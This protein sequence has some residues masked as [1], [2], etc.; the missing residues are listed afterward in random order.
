MRAMRIKLG[1]RSSPLAL[2]QTEL[3]RRAILA[4]RPELANC[5]DIVNINT[6][7]DQIRNCAIEVIGGRGVF[8]DE[9]DDAVAS[10]EVDL[11]VHSA[12]DLPV[13]I[14]PGLLLAATLGRED[15]REAFVSTQY[16]SLAAVPKNAVLGSASLRRET[17]VK[18]LRPDLSFSLLRGNV[19]ERVLA[20]DER[21]LNGTILAVAG[22]KR[23]GLERY[24]RE[25]FTP[26]TLMPDPG[27]GAIGI[28]CRSD[29]AVARAIASRVNHVLT[30]KAVIAE[31]AFLE[32]AAGR[33]VVGALACI[34]NQVFTLSA[35]AATLD[36][37]IVWHQSRQGCSSAP[38]ALAQRLA[39]CLPHSVAQGRT[40]S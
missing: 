38:L 5:I 9:L 20:L 12:K 32:A 6:R 30:Y 25:V 29:N 36:G 23:L 17:L 1:T 22:L 40:A 37:T 26:Q 24:I 28:V 19:D 21:R 15:P 35:V 10:G 39:A 27:Q 34:S 13:P 14:S 3:V 31:R 7:G 4:V 33:F 2:V 11:A 18:V 8:T 16:Q